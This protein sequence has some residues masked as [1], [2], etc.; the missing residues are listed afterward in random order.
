[1]SENKQNHEIASAPFQE[2]VSVLIR[3]ADAIKAALGL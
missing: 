2:R 3:S 1:M